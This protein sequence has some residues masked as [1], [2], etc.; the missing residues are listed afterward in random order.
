MTFTEEESSRLILLRA[1]EW[2]SLPVFATRTI[3]PITLFWLPWWQVCLALVACSLFWCPIRTRFVSL[4]VAMV[5]SRTNNL[6]VSLFANVVVAV[7]FFCTGRFALGLV[8]LLWQFIS[9][10]LAVAY[11]P[12]KLPIIREKLMAQL[13][14]GSA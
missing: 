1:L 14:E 8:A 5:V 6:Y 10:L 2:D 9:A 7:I 11:P 3:A 12:T 13:L 4:R